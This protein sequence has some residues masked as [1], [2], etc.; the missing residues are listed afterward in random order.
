MKRT[1]YCSDSYRMAGVVVKCIIAIVLI[2]IFGAAII[3][4]SILSTDNSIIT[5]LA[6]IKTNA[7][8]ISEYDIGHPKTQNSGD[9][10]HHA[11]NGINYEEQ[12]ERATEYGMVK[13]QELNNAYE[14]ADFTFGSVSPLADED[15]YAPGYTI[16]FNGVIS[17]EI[18]VYGWYD[19]R[20][21][22]TEMIA[23]Y[24]NSPD[25]E[26]I[27]AIANIY[28]CILNTYF[29]TERYSAEEDI[30]EELQYNSS[31]DGTTLY[32]DG[33]TSIYLG[34][35]PDG[36]WFAH[37]QTATGNTQ[38]AAEQLDGDVFSQLNNNDAGLARNYQE[39]INTVYGKNLVSFSSL[40]SDLNISGD[41]YITYDLLGTRY[42][43][44]SVYGYST[45]SGSWLDVSSLDVH[46][47]YS[48]DYGE[49]SEIL[50]SIIEGV[51]RINSSTFYKE[52]YNGC[53]FWEDNGTWDVY[54]TDSIWGTIWGESGYIML[55]LE[56]K[57]EAAE[58]E[59]AVEVDD[60]PSGDPGYFVGTLTVVNCEQWVSLREDPSTSAQ[61]L[62]E[63]PKWAEVD[64]YYYNDNWY[65]CFYE[66]KFGYILAEYLTDWPEKYDGY[67][68]R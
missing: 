54:I 53:R 50:D 57:E 34:I 62:A 37:M 38:N 39:S 42:G 15:E 64:A 59:E 9:D 48:D 44:C 2:S 31:W 60:D 4:N 47:V 45:G 52:I 30:R 12:V 13:V 63:V 21:W 24:I 55:H 25:E 35:H 49:S 43:Q 6:S 40:D 36:E 28:G 8:E 16:Y 68:D 58:A 3:C 46:I 33:T 29:G 10:L 51:F 67:Y 66:D 65:A 23:V 27:S 56:T 14:Y 1:I 61:R 41:K 19:S 32:L 20:Q 5:H 18:T 17:G 22:N 11:D 7:R 26:N